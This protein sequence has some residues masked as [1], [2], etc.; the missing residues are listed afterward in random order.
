VC[1]MSVWFGRTEIDEASAAHQRVVRSVAAL[2]DQLQPARLDPARQVVEL[3]G[4][5]TWVHLRHDSEPELEIRLV[6]CGS[7]ANFYGV[8][9]HDEAYSGS[10]ES[11]DAWEAETI[12]ILAD[13]LQAPYTFETYELAGK[14]WRED[15]TIGRPYYIQTFSSGP[16]LASFLPLRRWATR[17]QTRSSSFECCGS[18]PPSDR[19]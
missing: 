4:G 6:L 2:L 3:N 9:G 10:D 8:M 7:W 1:S 14:S 13:L 5:E 12:D 18:R 17:V 11:P 16:S 15:L 19:P